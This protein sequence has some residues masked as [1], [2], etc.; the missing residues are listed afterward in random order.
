MNWVGGVHYTVE[1]ATQL[2]S[3]SP[4][5]KDRLIKLTESQT[6]IKKALSITGIMLAIF[7]DRSVGIYRSD[8][9]CFLQSTLL[10]PTV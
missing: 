8:V 9:L 2:T 7:H 4:A 3:K 6:Q 1:A 5:V 10:S